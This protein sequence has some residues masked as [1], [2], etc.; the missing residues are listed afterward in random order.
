VPENGYL[1]REPERLATTRTTAELLDAPLLTCDDRLGRAH[2]HDA[3]A[4]VYPRSCAA[5][6]TESIGAEPS[7]TVH[8]ESQEAAAS[9]A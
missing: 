1:R 8:G 2:G 3:G 6:A 4:T 9:W 5:S 7:S